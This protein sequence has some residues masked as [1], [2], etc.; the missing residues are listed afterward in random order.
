MGH[1]GKKTFIS[2]Q[3]TSTHFCWE[4]WREADHTVVA[5]TSVSGHDTRV[6][7]HTTTDTIVAVNV[8]QNV[9]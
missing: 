5:M 6:E 9:G 7:A 1:A 4:Q 2:T 3:D 8:P